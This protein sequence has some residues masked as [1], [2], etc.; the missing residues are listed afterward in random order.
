MNPDQDLLIAERL[1]IERARA[2]LTQRQVGDRI[3]ASQN[4]VG[5]WERSE[6]VPDARQIARLA[7]LFGVCAD[8]LLGRTPHAHGLPTGHYLVD[9]DRAESGEPGNFAWII[10]A[11]AAVMRASEVEAL[12]RQKRKQR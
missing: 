9:M 11:R 12:M 7:D 3:G 8:Y 6:S 4:S 1:R 2:R 5:M 10:P